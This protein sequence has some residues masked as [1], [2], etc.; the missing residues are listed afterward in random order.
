MVFQSGCTHRQV[1]KFQVPRPLVSL[2]EVLLMLAIL[3]GSQCYLVVLICITL[4]TNHV[5]A[6]PY[7]FC[8]GQCFANILSQCWLAFS[9]SYVYL[10]CGKSSVLLE[11]NVLLF[12]GFCVVPRKHLSKPILSSVSFRGFIVFAVPRICD[13]VWFNFRAWCEVMVR[14]LTHDVQSF[15]TFTIWPPW[16][17]YWR[18]IVYR[19]VSLFLHSRLWPTER[20]VLMPVPHCPDYCSSRV[21]LEI[22]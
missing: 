5:E 3:V 4:L 2:P 11:S 21:N 8:E 22:R 19:N 20:H 13:L 6:L 12:Y 15:H 9:S 1:W 16:H 10:L 7:L 14:G 18:S 17:F